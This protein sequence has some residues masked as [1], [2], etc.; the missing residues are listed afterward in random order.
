MAAGVSP[1]RVG[2]FFRK[3]REKEDKNCEGMET[4]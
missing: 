1:K 3:K 2:V 4:L